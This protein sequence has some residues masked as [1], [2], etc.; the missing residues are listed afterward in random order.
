[1]STLSTTEYAT[2]FAGKTAIV[3][4]SA[5]GIGLAVARRLGQTGAAV[6]IADYNLEG[7]EQAAE[8][9]KSE[10]IK[11]AA[12]R[13]DVSDAASVEAGVRF[14]VDTFGALHLAV[15]NAGI[16]ADG[17]PVGE[18]D[19]DVWNRVVRTDLDG[20]F[21]SMRYEIPAMQAAGGGA[22]VNVSSILGSVAWAGSSAYV[23][24][25]HGVIGLTKTAALE[26]ADKGI[27]IN[28]VGPGFI[29]TPALQAMDQEAYAGLT[30]L[31]AT[32]RLGRPEE[33]AELVAFLLSDRASFVHGSYHLVD[34]AYTAR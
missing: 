33:V 16:G 21:Y 17:T 14:A 5:S 26:Y 18:Y 22:I 20:V 15:N 19:I 12:V 8:Q 32:G 31:H 3:T 4:G 1:M 30:A 13:V 27:R 9:L 7:A 29:E 28:A 23:A 10:G 6:V 2:E 24:A 25:K 11:A 34:G